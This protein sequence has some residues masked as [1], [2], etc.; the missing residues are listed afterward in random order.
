MKCT[1]L[2]S[3]FNG[4]KYTLNII[5]KAESIENGKEFNIELT[6]SSTKPYVKELKA[7]IKLIVN[8]KEDYV[9]T[10]NESGNGEYIILN[11]KINEPNKDITIKY[12]NTKLI[13]DKSSYLVNNANITTENNINSFT[14]RAE[15]IKNYEIY[16]VKKQED[17]VL[18][19][20]IVIN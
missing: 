11:L 1:L 3:D 14:V 20:D 8:Q 19:T 13:L 17:V 18:G 5:P 2:K 6:I 16:F 10:I 9:A 4:N 12:D 15:E 7:N